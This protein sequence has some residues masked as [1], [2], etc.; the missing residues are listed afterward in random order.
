MTFTA[1]FPG[2][3]GACE[4]RIHE[5]DLLTYRDDVDGA[6][7]ARCPD[8]VDPLA[9]PNTPLCSRCFTFHPGEC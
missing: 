5:G 8:L 1:Q 2:R 3:C 4:E 7:H 9:K 6:V